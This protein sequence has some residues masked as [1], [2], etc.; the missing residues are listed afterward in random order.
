VNLYTN[1]KEGRE[2]NWEN[3]IGPALAAVCI[4]REKV[5]LKDIFKIFI[6]EMLITY[7]L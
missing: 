5:V 2:I 3:Q 1:K 6:V 4:P 7:L